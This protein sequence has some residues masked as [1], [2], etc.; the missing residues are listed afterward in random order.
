MS[1]TTNNLLQLFSKLLQN[2]TIL[3][4]IRA[5]MFSDHIKNRDNRTGAQGLLVELW[6]KDGLS[7]SEISE[8]LDIKP[9][10][11][12]AQVK[13]LEKDGYVERIV[14]DNDRR[15]N[16]VFLTE[17]GKKAEKKRNCFHNDLSEDIFK[18]LSDDEKEQLRILMEKLTTA[19]V[20][21]DGNPHQRMRAFSDNPDMEN[22]MF[23]RDPHLFIGKWGQTRRPMSQQPRNA[24]KNKDDSMHDSNPFGDNWNF[25]T[26][27]FKDSLKKSFGD[28]NDAQFEKQFNDFMK[29]T[30]GKNGFSRQDRDEFGKYL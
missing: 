1:K 29:D 10:S 12:T 26:N 19:N 15:I 21:K 14:D 3:F 22:M 11:V 27:A 6:N 20:A 30:Y 8:L 7:N 18:S 16:R 25:E 5:N 9:S 13:Q 23:S 2:P 24:F 17:K 28:S 4:A